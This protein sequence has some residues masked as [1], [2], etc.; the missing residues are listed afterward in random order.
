MLC[1]AYAVVDLPLQQGANRSN[2]KWYCEDLQRRCGGKDAAAY[3]LHSVKHCTRLRTERS[4]A[5]RGSGADHHHPAITM[6]DNAHPAPG[7]LLQ[8]G[9]LHQAVAA[10]GVGVWEMD[11]TTGQE[12]WSDITLAMYGLP[13]GSPA[14]SR[15]QWREQFL[16]PDDAQRCADRAA[17]FLANFDATQRPYEM[18]YRIRRAGDGAIRWLHS[19]ASFAFGD[20]RRVLGITL[21]ITEQR[22]AEASAQ[23]ATLHLQHAA[24][25]LGFGFGWRDSDGGQGQWSEQLKRL[26][27]LPPDAPTPSGADVVQ[28]MLPADREPMLRAIAA[29]IPSGTVRHHSFGVLRG[30]DGGPRTLTTH[31]ATQYDSSG[32]PKRTHFAVLDSTEAE[33]QQRQVGELLL[34]LQL[35]TESCG[36]GT[37]ERDAH[38]GQ[39][40]WDTTMCALWGW[41][42]DQAAPNREQYLALLHPDDRA[43]AATH[44]EQVS[45]DRTPLDVELRVLRPDGQLRWLHTRARLE[46]DNEGRPLRRLGVCFDTT[47]RRQ[48]EAALH[49]KMLAEQASAA[50]TEFLSRMSHELRTPLNA[51]LGFAQLLALDTAEPLTDNQR[52]RVDHIQNAGWHLLSL[53]NDV[54]DLARIE[55]RQAPTQLGWVQLAPLVQECL[56]MSAPL[57]AQHGVTQLLQAE[58]GGP[59]Q[60]WADGTR[61]KQLLSNLLSNGIKYNRRGGQVQV[62]LAQRGDQAVIVVRDNGLGMNPQQQAQLFQPFNRLGREGS[63]IDGTG[64]GLALCKRIA[65]QMNGVI[66]FESTEGRGSEFRVLL[67]A[68]PP[69][70]QSLG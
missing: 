46:C 39:A 59:S 24:A 8:D 26:F 2:T 61:T 32:Q 68:A 57:A 23:E 12:L 52:Q 45:N 36:I 50:K 48:A 5:P 58:P 55:A 70:A 19:R 56:A 33:R 53:V 14:P 34:R 49:A 47:E 30:Q 67:P 66:E 54:L 20:R 44:W 13:P 29:P 15:S 43:V 35:A 22:E 3:V 64:I 11:F 60:L 31:A 18:E 10:A 1:G 27:G 28:L 65:E 16:H 6:T 25:Q 69:S 40:H 9:P 41:P 37:W 17:E 7:Q 51:V 63:G 42:A 21:D 4:P 38:T 62:L